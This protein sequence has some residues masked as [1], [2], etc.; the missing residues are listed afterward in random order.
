[1]Q[2]FIR[3]PLL[4]AYVGLPVCEIYW[5]IKRKIIHHNILLL[6]FMIYGNRQYRMIYDNVMQ[7]I[8]ETS[9]F[10]KRRCRNLYQVCRRR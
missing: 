3:D 9:K 5:T 6:L 4:Q 7:L 1:M 2:I 8:P 10:V